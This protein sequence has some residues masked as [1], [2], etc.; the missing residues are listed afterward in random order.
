MANWSNPT[1][2]STYTNFV[3]EVKD[4]DTDCA[5]FLDG[6]T[7]T[8][9]PTGAKR[10][11]STTN[12]FEKW[13]GTA[14][15]DLATTYAISISGNA[16]TAT[17]ATTAT[18]ATS[19]TTA[20][21]ATT[22]GNITGIAAA[23]NGGTGQS[24]Y[25]VGDLLYASGA[26]A[27]SK[28][29]DVATGNALISGGVGVAPSWG[30]VALTT[31][32]SGTLPVANGGTGVTT[33][34]GSGANVLATSPTF[35]TSAIAPLVIGGTTTTSPLALRATSGVGAAG[36]DIIFQVG[37]NGATEAMRVLN[38]GKVGIG[39]TTPEGTL[40]VVSTSAGGASF[41][42]VANGSASANSYAAISLD[43]GKNGFNVRDAQI[44]GINNGANQI[45]MAF[46]TSDAATP[47]ERMRIDHGGAV[48]ISRAT[49]YSDGAI[50]MPVLQA[51][52]YT[53]SKAAFATIADTTASTTAIGFVN[54]NGSV[55]GI[56]TSGTSTSYV[57][58]SD[59]RLK[60]NIAPM[61][62]ALEKVAA[63]KPVTYT[64]KSDGSTGQ[65]FIAHELQDVVPEAVTG[66][67]DDIGSN[68]KPIYQGIDPSKIIGLLTAAIQE[69]KAE[70]DALKAISP[71]P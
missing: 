18:T 27:L 24:S 62:G 14:W 52:A 44:R 16:A 42:R 13:S 15:S 25:A 45:S 21:T 23:A 17:S 40:D 56:A 58:S 29:A 53:G 59:Y 5:T 69:L 36:A 31:H 66:N 28:L 43:P 20:T 10:W 9:L 8:N 60:T 50:G 47:A 54:P 34:T 51:N 7:S 46:F 38:S 48:L 65:G 68:G 49:A 55:G 22:A 37:N 64:W 57:T 61:A 12:K 35:T 19:A 41:M 33:S 11:N 2:T 67:K 3:T 30:K 32:V 71:R 4:R 1:L 6:S 70:I 63:L 26:A 39:T